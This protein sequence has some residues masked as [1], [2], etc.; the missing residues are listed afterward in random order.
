[1]KKRIDLDEGTLIAFVAFILIAVFVKGEGYSPVVIAML[2]VATFL[3]GIFGAFVMQNRH[4]RLDALRTTLR[5]DDAAYVNMYKLSAAFGKK[6]QKRMQKLVDNYIIKT[7]D[8]RLPEY[9]CA[10]KEFLKLLEYITNLN[11]RNE[12]QR[13]NYSKLLDSIET[14]NTARKYVEY[15]TTNTMLRFK[16]LMLLGLLV[17]ILFSIFYINDNSLPSII[18]AVLL[19]TSSVM[20]LLIMR[21]LDSLYWKEQKWIWDPLEQLFGELDLLPYYPDEVIDRKR[22]KLKKGTKIRIASYPQPYPDHT[23]KTVKIKVV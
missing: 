4:K 18:T 2:S 21:D 7:I 20:F 17:V 15:L 16:W 5:K 8:Y 19:S 13:Q 9:R 3:F 12:R 14:A 23:G 11:P 22:V 10:N 6:V 1:M